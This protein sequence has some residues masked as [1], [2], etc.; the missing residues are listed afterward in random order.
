EAFNKELKFKEKIV[1]NLE[2]VRS[3]FT[4]FDEISNSKGHDYLNKKILK[5]VS[6]DVKRLLYRVRS[7]SELTIKIAEK[8]N[9]FLDKI[10]DYIKILIEAK[11]DQ[12][13]NTIDL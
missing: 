13:E 2:A 11:R 6:Y 9:E 7:T 1:A 4:Y 12:G 10:I 5:L 3:C 8:V